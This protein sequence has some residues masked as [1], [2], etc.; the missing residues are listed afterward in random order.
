MTDAQATAYAAANKEATA[1][2]AQTALDNLVAEKLAAEKAAAEKAE[3]ERLA[4]IEANRVALVA[5]AKAAGLTDA[6]ATAY[7]AANK[8]A[9]AA[10]AQT[11][12]DN[13]VA[14]KLAAEKA[15]AERLAAIEANR[16]A[17]VA[18][19][20]AAGLTDAQATAYAAA[21]KEADATAAQTALDNLVAENTKIA[22]AAEI[23]QAKGFSE[24]KY[25]IGQITAKT[26]IKNSNISNAITQESRIHS[27]VYNQNYSVV[28]GNYE[29]AITYN[30]STG[31]IISDNRNSTINV[32]GLMTALDA[33]PQLGTATYTGKAFN[34]TYQR[35]F[36]WNTY[37]T[38]ESIKEGKLTYNVD[39]TNRNGSGSITGLG[40][41]INLQQGSISG[42]GIS[43]IAQQ[44]FKNGNYSL[45]FYGKNAEEI[46]GKVAF[47]GKDTVG[48]GGT[49]GDITK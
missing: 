21:N 35:N 10:A 42:T 32:K 3:A 26:Q 30:N 25:P 43:A 4:A 46:A 34:G 39:F 12:L 48:F 18:K 7:A 9:T 2:A 11:A 31:A 40:D 15:E 14:E 29:G 6:Q 17:L 41:N 22:L 24:G 37:Q 23:A 47:D 1:A 16:V 28:L 33:I 44:G 20:K 38:S 8:E 45:D 5:K 19:A 49:R 36:D 13:L 27:V